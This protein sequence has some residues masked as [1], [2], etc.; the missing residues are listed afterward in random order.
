M[1]NRERVVNMKWTKF[2]LL[3]WL[4]ALRRRK[5]PPNFCFIAALNSNTEIKLIMKTRPHYDATTA[6]LRKVVKCCCPIK[7]H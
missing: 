4:K 2:V 5:H 7:M 6:V 1:T 3:I